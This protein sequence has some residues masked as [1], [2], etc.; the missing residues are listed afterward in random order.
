MS[1]NLAEILLICSRQ[2]PEGLRVM[3][4]DEEKNQDAL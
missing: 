4:E 1:F 3:A 2:T